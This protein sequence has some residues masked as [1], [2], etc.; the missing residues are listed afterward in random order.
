MER[1][2]Y[3]DFT[4]KARTDDHA[5]LEKILMASGATF[6]GSDFQRDTYFKTRQGKLKLRQ[7]NLENLITHY[8]RIEEHGI[9]RTDVYR[10]DPDPT[11]EEIQSLV[12]SHDELGIVEKERKIFYLGDVK[13]H[14][15]TL[16]DKK[17]YVEI[18]AIDRTDAKDIESLRQQCIAVKNTLGI[19][20]EDLLKTG[21]LPI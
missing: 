5:V 1:L 20:D 14:L 2:P 11:S 9:E 16:P 13:V 19:K 10:F 8:E 4:L 18:E 15:D 7:G 3:K 21:Y 6:I 12:Y 17:M